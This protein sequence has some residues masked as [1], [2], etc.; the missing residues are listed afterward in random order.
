MKK[1]M[2]SICASFAMTAGVALAQ[3]FTITRHVVPQTEPARPPV[4][5]NS[6]SSWF[7]K[8]M[9]AP[10][11]LQLVNPLAPRQYGSGAQVVVADPQD[12]QERPYAVRLFSIAFWSEIAF[13]HDPGFISSRTCQLLSIVERTTNKID[14]SRPKKA[15]GAESMRDNDK[16]SEVLIPIPIAQREACDR[17]RFIAGDNAAKTQE[18]VISASL[19]WNQ[20]IQLSPLRD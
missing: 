13:Q 9:A 12:P 14:H 11:K 5:Q 20:N 7:R 19:I 1:L 10:N 2:I 6:N 16:A 18:G 15:R 3:E 4:E 17:R 8:F